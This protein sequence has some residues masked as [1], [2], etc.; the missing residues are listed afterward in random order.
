MYLTNQQSITRMPT[1][2]YQQLQDSD[3]GLQQLLLLLLLWLL[4]AKNKTSR[5]LHIH[6]VNQS[7]LTR[8]QVSNRLQHNSLND[9]ATNQ[10]R[11]QHRRER[12]SSDTAGSTL[13]LPER[14]CVAVA[15]P[16]ATASKAASTL[17]SFVA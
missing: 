12:E 5:G 2:Y 6:V 13:G 8:T 9:V 10:T 7:T 14:L 16:D 15:I 17:S 4:L 1:T 3:D 11:K